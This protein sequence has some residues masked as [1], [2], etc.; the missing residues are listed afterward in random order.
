MMRST[1]SWSAEAL[2]KASLALVSSFSQD[3]VFVWL[4]EEI[5][6]VRQ[7]GSAGHT[8]AEQRQRQPD[9]NAG[10]AATELGG[11]ELPVLVII[12]RRRACMLLLNSM[13]VHTQM[14]CTRY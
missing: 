12:V 2:V 3:G 10:Q 4:Q 7:H 14:I 9:P 6:A 5:N 11:D 1:R 8:I 13:I